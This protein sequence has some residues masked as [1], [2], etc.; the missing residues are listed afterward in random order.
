MAALQETN[1]TQRLILG[2]FALTLVLLVAILL[3]DPE[4]YDSTLN[5]GPGP[6]LIPDLAFL[7]AISAFVALLVAGVLRRWRWTFWLV[8]VAFL[9]G[10]FRLIASVLQLM[11]VLPATGPDWYMELQ[12]AIGIIQFLIALEMIAGYRR[13]GVW[14][15]F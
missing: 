14:G 11:A 9:G 5:L 10:I 8:L 4:L 15:T 2:F 6:H 7:T 3:F 13:G 1:R 12:G